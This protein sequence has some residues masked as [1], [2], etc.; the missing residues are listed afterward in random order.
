MNVTLNQGILAV[1]CSLVLCSGKAFSDEVNFW[2][3][4]SRKSVEWSDDSNWEAR[5]APARDG[6]GRVIF[7][8]DSQ[9]ESHPDGEWRL[10]TLEFSKKSVS[11]LLTGEKSLLVFDPQKEKEA[12]GIVNDSRETQT[13]DVDIRLGGSQTWIANA[14]Q[15]VIGQPKSERTLALADYTL[16]LDGEGKFQ[17]FSVISEKGNLVK[18]GSGLLTLSGNNTYTGST[19]LQAGVTQVHGDQSAATGD[20]I[21]DGKATLVGNGNIGGNTTVFGTHSAGDAEHEVGSQT[22]RSDLSYESGSIFSWDLGANSEKEGFDQIFGEGRLAIAKDAVFQIVLGKGVELEDGFWNSDHS[23]KSIFNGLSGGEFN[24]E[25]LQVIRSDGSAADFLERGTFS[26]SGTTVNWSP[27]GWSPVPEP[28]S[29][30]AG[31]LVVA[32][33]LRRRRG[34]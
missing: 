23:W 13:V 26:I 9:T 5:R 10:Q 8:A 7:Q 16:T 21:V 17:I 22:F 6:A 32:G 15:L 14:G 1:A 29:A 4:D 2:T 34:A 30:L 25:F 11:H 19:R 12:Y 27:H 28:G 20:W 3:N 33:M 31:L 24:P 18:S